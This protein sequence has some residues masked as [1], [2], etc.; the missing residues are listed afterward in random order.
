MRNRHLLPYRQRTIAA[1]EGRVL[2][3]GIGSGLNLR[4]YSAHVNEIVELEPAPRLRGAGSPVTL[5][6]ERNLPQ[7][8]ERMENL[9][10][11]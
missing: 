5:R 7:L 8:L 10:G 3:I 6:G 2:E 11:A 4:F 9:R 1:A